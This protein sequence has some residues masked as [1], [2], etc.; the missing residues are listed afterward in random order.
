MTHMFWICSGSVY[1]GGGPTLGVPDASAQ[2]FH[3]FSFFGGILNEFPFQ[4]LQCGFARRPQPTK[5]CETASSFN[6]PL[7]FISADGP[8]LGS[9]IID[10]FSDRDLWFSTLFQLIQPSGLLR[11]LCVNLVEIASSKFQALWMGAG[12]LLSQ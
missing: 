5:L 12:Y 8:L 9:S 1:H 7:G 2:I 4:N 3:G 10:F 6:A 11:V